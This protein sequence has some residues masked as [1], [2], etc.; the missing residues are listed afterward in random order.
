MCGCFALYTS[1][2]VLA[3]LFDPPK[4]PVPVP[5][6]SIAPIQSFAIAGP[7]EHGHGPDGSDL[8]LCILLATKPK[9]VMVPLHNRIP[10][11]IAPE[12][13]RDV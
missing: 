5:R 2:N 4:T 13:Y 12:D 3:Q 6:Y 11:I 8:E 1:A 9:E 10:V 7:W